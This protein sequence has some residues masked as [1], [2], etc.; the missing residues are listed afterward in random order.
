MFILGITGG[1]GSG[2]STV[3]ELLAPLG[4]HVLDADRISKDLAL[5]DPEF[6]EIYVKIF[7]PEAKCEDGTLNRAFIADIVFRDKEKLAHLGKETHLA[8]MT[9]I[10]QEIA[11]LEEEASSA[12]KPYP[13]NILLD[14]PIPVQKG[15]LDRCDLIVVVEAE[16]HLRLRRLT[17]RGLS[18]LD[19]KNRMA[20][21]MSDEE[22]AA[23]AD[24]VV[25]NSG[26]LDDLKREVQ[27]KVYPLL[28][29]RGI[30]VGSYTERSKGSEDLS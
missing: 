15:F 17:Q 6:Q 3:T 7:G 13:L 22:Y 26:D 8:I 12:K 9:W 23:L 21:Q 18:S 4:F 10:N 16:Q 11:R 30:V 24:C 29:A 25:N 19:A 28:E 2:K 20:M 27:S 14:F 1:I 5:H